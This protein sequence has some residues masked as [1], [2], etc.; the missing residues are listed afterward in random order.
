MQVT[1]GSWK[2]LL[3]VE[4]PVNVVLINWVHW[5]GTLGLNKVFTLS[6]LAVS[7]NKKN[8]GLHQVFT[9]SI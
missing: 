5:N 1:L 6:I 2:T 9:L 7:E 3:S 4:S 8:L